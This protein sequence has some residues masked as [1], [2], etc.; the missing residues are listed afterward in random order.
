MRRSKPDAPAS[1]ARWEPWPKPNRWYDWLSEKSKP[2]RC[3]VCKE[4]LFR[5]AIDPMDLYAAAGAGWPGEPIAVCLG[6][7]R[8][9]WRR[10]WYHQSCCGVYASRTNLAGGWVTF[11]YIP[12]AFRVRERGYSESEQ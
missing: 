9:L 3:R 8:N 11:G 5:G 12:E 6:S 7:W 10:K 4:I 2:R 1:P